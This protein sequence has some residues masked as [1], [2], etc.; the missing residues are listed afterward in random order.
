MYDL[1]PHRMRLMAFQCA[2]HGILMCDSR[3]FSVRFM[4]FRYVT[5]REFGIRSLCNKPAFVNDVNIQRRFLWQK[6]VRNESCNQV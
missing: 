1:N 5:Q 6:V 3:H 4:V 2:I